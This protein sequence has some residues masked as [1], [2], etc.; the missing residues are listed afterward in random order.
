MNTNEIHAL[1]RKFIAIA[2]VSFFLVIAFVGLLINMFTYV[3]NQREIY[4][5]LKQIIQH[6]D[7]IEEIYEDEENLQDLPSFLEVFSPSYQHTV[8][9]IL[10]YDDTGEEA[11]FF[12]NRDNS[13]AESVVEETAS[14]IMQLKP[15]RGRYGMYYYQ[16]AA[17]EDGGQTLAIL[18]SSYMIYTRIRLLYASLGVGFLSLI[19]TLILV[20]VL[21]KKMIQ[22]EIEAS[23]RQIQFLT[24][25][26]HELKTPLAVIRSNAEM[27]EMLQ[28]ETE[29]TQSTIRQVDRMSGLIKN[30]VMI[31]K[32]REKETR[33]LDGPIDA[34]DAVAQTSQEFS[35]MAESA[36]K[37]LRTQIEPHVQIAFDESTLRQLAMI[38]LDNAVKY[39]DPDGEILVSLERLK[40]GR[41]T[42]RL[43]VSNTY[44]AG[45]DVD[46]SRFF[47]RFYR[48]DTS[49]NIDTGGYGIGLS[50]A[51]SIC[52]QNDG[53]IT[54]H[55]KNDVISFTCEF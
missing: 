49:H 15:F 37:T 4:W 35:A 45:K 31:T 50:I 41:R 26:S 6:K 38:L 32:T 19:A 3:L 27:E 34:S 16:K 8:F 2:M 25:V 24:N 28:G 40:R 46:Y 17:S 55:W 52:R 13:Y 23:Q 51:E 29:W 11:S 44:A 18:D 39:C 22:P 12:S 7:S 36:G 48:E 42:L 9:Y 53:S 54:A 47:D 33:A 1:R 14:L 43:T 21:S 5:S 20:I 30:L 10:Q